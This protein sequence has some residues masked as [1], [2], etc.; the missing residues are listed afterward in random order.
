MTQV[1]D[2]VIAI[3]MLNANSFTVNTGKESKTKLDREKMPTLKI[4][5]ESWDV[6][7]PHKKSA[8]VFLLHLLD[9]NDNQP[10]FEQQSYELN[11]RENNRV[12]DII[13]QFKALDSDAGLNGQVSYGVLPITPSLLENNKTYFVSID[14]NT[15]ILRAAVEFDRES[16]HTYEFYVVARDNGLSGA[17]LQSQVKCTLSIV[18]EN[19][20]APLISYQIDQG[21]KEVAN[22]SLVVLNVDEN[23]PVLTELVRFACQ[24][25][26]SDHNGRTSLQL[27]SQTRHE[28]GSYQQQNLFMR[29]SNARPLNTNEIPF[30]LSAE[31]SLF[32]RDRLDREQVRIHNS[33]KT[34]FLLI[35]LLFKKIYYYS[36]EKKHVFFATNYM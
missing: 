36:R 9:L 13:Y 14:G 7:E 28:Y 2:E 8:Y 31:G 29:M 18:D 5:I 16:E 25:A 15:G 12:G 6:A 32:V 17:R 24:D 10:V 21:F 34:L 1:F 3:S 27:V 35:L 33:S 20:N 26:D 22:E 30:G 11:T 4:T 23:I 19:D